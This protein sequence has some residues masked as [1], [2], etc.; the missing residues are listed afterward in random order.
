LGLGLGLELEL[1]GMCE[2]GERRR[3]PNPSILMKYE[4]EEN[5]PKMGVIDWVRVKVKVKAKVKV[6]VKVKV[7]G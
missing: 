3:R 7:K 4:M 1:G 6:K 5:H 2:E